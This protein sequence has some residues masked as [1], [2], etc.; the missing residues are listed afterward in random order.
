MTHADDDTNQAAADIL[1]MTDALYVPKHEY[2]PADLKEFKQLSWRFYEQAR[3]LLEREG[4]RSMGDYEDLTVSNAPDGVRTVIRTLLN[5][6]GTIQSSVFHFRPKLF[7]RLLMRLAG[8]GSGKIVDFE[9]EFSNGH[10]VNTTNA[11]SA[12]AMGQPPEIRTEYMKAGTSAL[13]LL[14]RHKERIHAYQKENPT[15]RPKIMQSARDILESQHRQEAIKSTFRKSIG[16]VSQEELR[17]LS[18]GKTEMAD[19]IY[20]EIKKIQGRD[21]DNLSNLSP[22]QDA[23]LDDAIKEHNTKNDILMKEWGFGDP[24]EWGF[25]QTS[26]RFFIIGKTGARVEASGQIY[27]SFSATDR[28][29]EWAWNNPYVADSLKQDALLV[30]AYGRKEN[31]GYLCQGKLLLPD[32]TAA[33]YFAAIA[34]KLSG[35]QGVFPAR[36]GSLIVY[37]GLKNLIRK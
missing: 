13:D 31:L 21:T 4:F 37:I 30:Q 32:E 16:G 19:E 14:S 23:L 3:S 28:S 29:W 24:K 33:T 8:G 7:M 36:S 26:G 15:V 9:T 12:A 25:D 35:A 22:E 34:E 17:N 27:G 11:M 2:A 20:D 5:S 18:R 1:A 10:F 6:D